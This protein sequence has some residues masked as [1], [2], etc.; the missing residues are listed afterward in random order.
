MHRFDKDTRVTTRVRGFGRG[1]HEQVGQWFGGESVLLHLA[2]DGR[3]KNVG[4]LY[5]DLRIFF[6]PRMEHVHLMR[7]QN[8]YGLSVRLLDWLNP[9]ADEVH[10]YVFDPE[11][12]LAKVHIEDSFTLDEFKRT[13]TDLE[14][15]PYEGID[16]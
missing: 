11:K 16:L 4:I 2:E 3:P 7:R 8:G 5:R 6:A 1:A 13:L 15:P 14:A 12:K 9:V 10:V